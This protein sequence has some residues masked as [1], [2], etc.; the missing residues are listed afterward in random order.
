[1]KHSWVLIV[2]FVL[3][4]P[5]VR[6]DVGDQYRAAGWEFRDDDYD[7]SLERACKPF[8]AADEQAKLR[9]FPDWR[10]TL[11]AGLTVT[12]GGSDRGFGT[13]GLH[14]HGELQPSWHDHPNV[15]LRGVVEPMWAG[16]FG[17]TGE[18]AIGLYVGHDYGTF[19][20]GARN[21][22]VAETSTTTVGDVEYTK[23]TIT[24]VHVPSVCTVA[25]RDLAVY[26]GVRPGLWLGTTFTDPTTGLNVSAPVE[27]MIPLELGV[28]RLVRGADQKYLEWQI[29]VLADPLYGGRFGAYIRVARPLFGV[30]T[31][32]DMTLL[33]GGD[34][35][36]FLLTASFGWRGE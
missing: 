13:T 21:Y 9:E 3:A 25:S 35:T 18:A 36:I 11:S 30:Y 23:T 26:A 10:K 1:M 2:G 32:G 16:R 4:S 20:R 27:G 22:L 15:F 29:A 28:N 33:A 17:V 5:P 31:A 12:A 6:G 24:P 19:Y 14:V 7:G 8:P 34:H